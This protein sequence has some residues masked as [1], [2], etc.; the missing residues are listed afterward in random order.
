[1]KNL[2]AKSMSRKKWAIVTTS[3][4]VILT[5]AGL[6]IFEGTKSS[7]AV[8]VDGKKKTIHTHASTVAELLKE[9]NISL[10]SNDYLN[11]PTNAKVTDDLKVVWEPAKQVTI[12]IGD[13]TEK[14]WTTAKTVD[15]LLKDRQIGMK[16]QDKLIPSEK[17]AIKRNMTIKIDPAFLVTVN[18]GGKEKKVWSTSTTVADFLK[19]QGMGLN[20]LDRI[21]PGLN[22]NLHQN[23]V[24]DIVRVQKVI[25]VVE[26]SK[27]FTVEKK[28]DST[29]ETGK[30]KVVKQ[31]QTGLVVKRFQVL[32]INGKEVSRKLVNQEVVKPIKNKVVAVGTKEVKRSS[33]LVATKVSTNNQSA[34]YESGGREIYM[35]S[36]AYTASCNGCSG[37]TAT[38]INLKANP[39]M[40]LIAVDP[41]IIPL[42]SRVYV[43][44]YGYAIAGDTGGAINGHKIDVFF[45]SKSEAYSWGQRQVR[46]RIIE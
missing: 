23:D 29:L 19:Q 46:V 37:F 32:K 41:S 28:E 16:E 22:N 21:Q 45:S 36:T 7:V 14:I 25:D 34:A 40:K 6:F 12:I 38:G 15:Q 9:L 11:F 1:M 39:N 30:E 4:I 5:T 18:D 31:G 17:S 3:M 26:E 35:N 33:Q 8:S 27:S 42:G 20:S 44:G 13:Y 10:N 43:E 2:F 24:I